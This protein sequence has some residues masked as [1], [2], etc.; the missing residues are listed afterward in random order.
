[1]RMDVGV[2]YEGC[3]GVHRRDLQVRMNADDDDLGRH[4]DVG[5]LSGDSRGSAGGRNAARGSGSEGT[6]CDG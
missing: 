3:G 2:W 6:G 1:M 4:D 5:W